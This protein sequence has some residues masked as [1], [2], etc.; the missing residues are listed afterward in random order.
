MSVVTPSST[1]LGRL[2]FLDEFKDANPHLKKNLDKPH[3]GSLWTL[4]TDRHRWDGDCCLL[5]QGL[6]YGCF[7]DHYEMW[8]DTNTGLP[9]IIGHPYCCHT[10]KCLNCRHSIPEDREENESSHHHV[11]DAD[12]LAER[13]LWWQVSNASWYS[14]ATSLVVIA[15]VDVLET[16]TL[17]IDHDKLA[18]WH[19]QDKSLPL[20]PS[21]DY[22]IIEARK[23]A[24]ESVIR[25]RRS[26]K[27]PEAEASGD[28]QSALYFYCDTAYE[29]RTGGF[30]R[31]AREQLAD[32]KRIVTAHPD[33][34]TTFLHFKN[35]RDREFICGKPQPTPSRLHLEGRLR[36]LRLPDTWG[37]FASNEPGHA[38]ATIGTEKGGYAKFSE[39]GDVRITQGGNLNLWKATVDFGSGPSISTVSDGVPRS[40]FSPQN[41]C[42]ETPEAAVEGAI[43]I[44]R[45]FDELTGAER[46]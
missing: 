43:D 46:Q 44:W 6:N 23:L 32:A 29:D 33:L 42:Y 45:R 27:A 28:Y 17:P 38:Y 15:R 9:V 7:L 18:L 39:G 3:C 31:L 5:D 14:E 20:W 41:Y 40:L 26:Q 36:R 21:I 30:H 13:G 8:E 10:E 35:R 24:E 37:P 2:M 16:I 19:E 12:F 1:S 22:E 25:N 11:E 4:L 34:D